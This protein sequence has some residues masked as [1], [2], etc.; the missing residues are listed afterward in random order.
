PAGEFIYV[1]EAENEQE[2]AVHVVR[3]IWE[4]VRAK[5]RTYGDFAILYR[6]NA[7]SRIFEE[8]FLNSST[9]YRIIGGLRFYERKEVKDLIAYL[10]VIHNPLDSVS[11]KRIINV[12][13]RAIGSTTISALE[14]ESQETGTTLWDAV[15]E[16]NKIQSLALRARNA[17]SG[18]AAI[19]K[20][21]RAMRENSTVTDLASAVLDATG[22]LRELEAEQT[23]EGQTRAENVRELLT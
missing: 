11:L 3:K 2:E 15:S 8:V 5:E 7:Q 17:V 14:R 4:A 19:I 9:P 21:L 16:V 6:T 18:F 10:R 13:T 1:K 20:G 23:I 22:Y 12:P